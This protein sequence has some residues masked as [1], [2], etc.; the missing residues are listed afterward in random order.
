[1]I[2][3]PTPTPA[4]RPVFATTHWTQVLAAGQDSDA[5]AA[6]CRVYWYPLYAFVRRKG[7]QSAD[8]EDLTQEFFARLLERNSLREVK[9]EGGR[10]RSFLLSALDHFLV[11]E[12]RKASA[13]K[14]GAGKVVSLDAREAE[15]RYLREPVEN[16]TPERLFEQSA[17]L[18]LLEE[19]YAALRLEYAGEADL[20]ESLKGALLGDGSV[21][22][23]QAL[24]E[25]F[26]LS[27]GG[28]KT[29]VHRM[30]QRFRKLLRETV[31]RT[32][33]SSAEVD[34]ELRYLLRALT[35]P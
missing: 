16:V 5:L 22:P 8:A 17:A 29:H 23:Y 27:E 34:E 4:Q 35:S 3:P 2:T 26:H 31:A 9:R 18:A 1:M 6:L 28:I 7:Y 30:R 11:D 12:W 15:T 10:F 14:R 13:K 20:F 19:V 32:V 24:A 21:L 33:S 25:R